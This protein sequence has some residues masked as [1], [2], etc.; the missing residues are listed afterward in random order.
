MSKPDK[1]NQAM[2]SDMDVWFITHRIIMVAA[3]E[4]KRAAYEMKKAAQLVN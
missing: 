1:K 3:K 2:N 4:L